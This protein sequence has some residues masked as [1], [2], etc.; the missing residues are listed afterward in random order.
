MLPR[1]RDEPPHAGVSVLTF[2]QQQQKQQRLRKCIQDAGRRV[3]LLDEESNGPNMRVTF[4]TSPKHAA[5][6]N[7]PSAAHPTPSL[8]PFM[9]SPQLL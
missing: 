4:I 7:I 3:L 5:S 8:G 9:R 1:V 2:H 6:A